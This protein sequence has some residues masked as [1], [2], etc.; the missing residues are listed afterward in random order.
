[1][2]IKRSM[3]I[4]ALIALFIGCYAM[5]N[6]HYD[7]LARYPHT[8]NEQ[9]RELV[10]HHLNTDEIN[11]LI[12]WKIEPKEFLPYI[13]VDGFVLENTLWYDEMAN[14]TKEKVSKEFIV[15]FINKYKEQMNFN[16]LQYL[17]A[18]YSYNELI[19]FFD[20]GDLYQKSARLIPN[21]SDIY[22]MIANRR[23][24]Y[25][26]EPK[27]LVSIGSLPHSS[28]VPKAY[29]IVVKKAILEPLQL[30]CKSAEVIDD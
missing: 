14:T 8:L 7:E 2:K 28:I 24:L 21:P 22:T 3:L 10:L 29:D 5:M 23:T 19:R 1:M 9:Q 6:K 25:T 11:T 26:Y 16:D 13:E 30:L 12:S 15:A 27:D 17:L 4:V 18:N 20:E